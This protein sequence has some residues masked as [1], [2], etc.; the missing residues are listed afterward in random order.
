MSDTGKDLRSRK[1]RPC[2]PGGLPPLAAQQ[3]RTYL[4]SVP[5]WTQSG[6][7]T[8]ISREYRLADFQAAMDFLRRVAEVAEAEDH[9]PDIHLTGLRNVT[10]ELWTHALGGL[11][12]NDFIVAAKIDAL[13]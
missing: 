5:Q 11:S 7:G 10:L 12:E 8:R 9:H 3:V 6:D 1:C 13:S 4:A 2:G